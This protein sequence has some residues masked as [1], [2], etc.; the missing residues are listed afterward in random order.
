MARGRFGLSSPR[1]TSIG[2]QGPLSV[3]VPR[4]IK[5]QEQRV[6]LTPDLC[7]ELVQAGSPVAVQAGAGRFAGHTDDDYRSASPIE[8]VRPGFP[9]T[10]FC[11]PMTA[12]K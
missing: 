2:T 6:A 9:P 4:E 8:Y 5:P 11:F 3:F 1:M 7:V 10:P 12:M